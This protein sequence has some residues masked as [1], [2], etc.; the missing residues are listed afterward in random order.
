MLS[1]RNNTEEEGLYYTSTDDDDA[2]LLPVFGQQRRMLKEF[3]DVPLLFQ[4]EGEMH[5]EAIVWRQHLI[6]R[7]GYQLEENRCQ[8]P[9]HSQ[10]D[11]RM[12]WPD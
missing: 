5:R 3:D 7:L 4:K 9:G 11:H 8:G 1:F 2:T 12:L 10:T 6:Q